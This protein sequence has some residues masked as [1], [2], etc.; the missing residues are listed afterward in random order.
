MPGSQKQIAKAAMLIKG[1][2]E[3]QK[4]SGEPACPTK[5]KQ[6]KQNPNKKKK[7]TLRREWS[8]PPPERH[9]RQH[10]QRWICLVLSFHAVAL[11]GSCYSYPLG[12][13][14]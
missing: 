2:L 6:H 9:T 12:L 14:F 10:P 4:S 13:V 5:P 1:R 3:L 11:I 8:S 7:K